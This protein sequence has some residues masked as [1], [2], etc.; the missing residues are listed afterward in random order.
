MRRNRKVIGIEQQAHGHTADIDR[1]LSIGW[2]ADDTTTLLRFL[3][4]PNAD[5]FG[6]SM[7]AAVALQ[8]AIRH[9]EL[10]RKLVIASVSYPGDKETAV[11]LL[12]LG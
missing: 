11:D 4:I 9:P 2:M 10:V 12:D 5:I 8:I 1:P 6:Y 3:G 7:G